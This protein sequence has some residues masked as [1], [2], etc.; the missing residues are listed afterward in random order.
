MDKD[1]PKITLL[2][3]EHIAEIVQL[4]LENFPTE[5]FGYPGKCLLGIYYH[6]IIHSEGASGFVILAGDQL[7]GY[8]CGIFN[9][10]K[11]NSYLYRKH[12]AAL[13][14][15]SLCQVVVSPQWAQSLYQRLRAR[16]DGLSIKGGYELRPIVIHPTAR[17]K[18][19]GTKLIEILKKDALVRGFDRIYLFV[20]SDN[21]R[22][23][24]FYY[25]NGF[26]KISTVFQH[27][28]RYGLFESST[29]EVAV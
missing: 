14:F 3:D 29:A 10:S 15:W 8:I 16:P 11:L 9:R 23:Q 22:A 24:N 25:R 26:T 1:T 13:V 6:A 7:I 5:F 2:S 17:S 4:H 20:E 12:W 18:G 27:G 28:K 19:Y 21:L